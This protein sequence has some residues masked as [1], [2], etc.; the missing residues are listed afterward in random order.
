MIAISVIIPV[1]NAEKF[2]EHAV[3]SALVHAEVKEILLIEDGSPDNS[4][5]V[6]KQ[7]ERF[8]EKVKLL[9]HKDGKNKG[10]SASR[11]FGMK[12]AS[13]PFI[14][15]L[16]ADDYYLPN[17]FEAEKKI[18]DNDPGVDGVYGALGF[19][20]YSEEYKEK[21]IKVFNTDL[22]T[23]KGNIPPEKLKYI[24]LG[25]CREDKGYFHLN[26]LTIKKQLAEKAGYI[27][28]EFDFHEDTH[29]INKLSFTGKLVPGIIDKPIGMRG[30]HDSNRITTDRNNAYSKYLMLNNFE[31]WIYKEVEGEEQAKRFVTK[32][33]MVYQLLSSKQ[34]RFNKSSQ[35]LK[36]FKK[37]PYAFYI[38]YS[39]N[40]LIN[41]IY[42]GRIGRIF[43]QLRQK[44]F[45]TVFRKQAQKWDLIIY[46][47]YCD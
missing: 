35:L 19:H 40:I 28:E 5:Q 34:N 3:K 39:F 38:Q 25:M 12:C 44:A 17:R 4:L 42:G 23:V 22:T 2:V 47:N 20:Y 27:S 29:F 9:R 45:N 36:L 41:G 16:D 14:S 11:N 15:F 32:D 13:Q 7:L 26:T 46:D 30:V 1:Y 18:F 21:Y 37:E 10:A 24:L 43:I 33:R 31:K 8:S 6:C